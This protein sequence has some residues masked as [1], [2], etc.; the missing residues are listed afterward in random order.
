MD[1]RTIVIIDDDSTTRKVLQWVLE[2][3]GFVV[4][5][6]SDAEEAIGLCREPQLAVAA[7]IA[8]VRLR[9]R[10]TGIDVAMAVRREFP[11]LPVLI[12][13]GTPPQGWAEQDRAVFEELLKNRADFLDKPFTAGMLAEKIAALVS[14]QPR[15]PAP[16]K[17]DAGASALRAQAPAGE[18]D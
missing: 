15:P 16:P 17:R 1:L 8:D 10:M 12:I 5:A 4:V 7:M 6:V 2:R 11:D 9:S 18:S 13:S 3:H 14:A